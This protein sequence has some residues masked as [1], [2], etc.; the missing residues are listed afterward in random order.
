MNNNLEKYKTIFRQQFNVEDEGL[1]QLEYK[2][3]PEWNSMAHIS[4]VGAIEEE[5]G[6]CFEAEDIFALKSYEQ[7]KELLKERF[8][9]GIDL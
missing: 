2:Q 7:G 9:I 4:L 1:S 8:G 6:I 3:Y 5:F